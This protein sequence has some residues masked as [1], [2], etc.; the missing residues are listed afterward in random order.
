MQVKIPAEAVSQLQWSV[1]CSIYIP[2][3][4]EMKTERRGR[5]EQSWRETARCG[6]SV[7]E[8]GE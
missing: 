4:I 5:E 8:E 7:G 6:E 1:S 3:E 2:S